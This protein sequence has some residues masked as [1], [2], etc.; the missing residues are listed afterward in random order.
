[1]SCMRRTALQ[2]SIGMT[3]LE[4]TPYLHGRPTSEIRLRRTR[5]GMRYASAQTYISSGFHFPRG[6]NHSSVSLRIPNYRRSSLPSAL[7]ESIACH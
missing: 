7:R 3:C 6:D 4:N 1:M 5:C 2:Q